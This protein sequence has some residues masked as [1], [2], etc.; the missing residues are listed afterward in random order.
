MATLISRRQFTI[1]WGHC[2][3]A[4][5]VFNAR[6]LSSSIGAP[7]LFEAALGVKP[8][9][10]GKVFGIIGIPLVDAG[11]RFS[12]GAFGDIVEIA[13]HV[14]EFRCS[15]FDVEHR[16]LIARRDRGRRQRNAGLG[17]ARSGRSGQDQIAA[18]SPEVHRAFCDGLT[19]AAATTPRPGS[20][21]I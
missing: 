19:R 1:E 18:D 4:G 11:A 17:G 8:H 3:P 20:V 7:D 9:G 6:F 15:S 2:D 14:S 13:S 12:R 21:L 5:I 16:I 10:L